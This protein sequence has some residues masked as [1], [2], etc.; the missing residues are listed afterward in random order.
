M[1]QEERIHANAGALVDVLTK[2]T[3][4][5]AKWSKQQKLKGRS[6]GFLYRNPKTHRPVLITAG[7]KMPK[8]GCFIETRMR[9]DKGHML[10]INAGK[11][12]VF[13]KQSKID[14]AFSELPIE[15]YQK[16]IEKYDGIDIIQYQAPFKNADPKEPH[17]FAVVNNYEFTK[18]E[19]GY[20]VPVYLCYEVGM[21]LIRQDENF[22][23][24]KPNREFQGD[25]YYE[26]ASGAPI[27]DSNGAISSILVS[28]DKAEGILKAFR[29]DNFDFDAHLNTSSKS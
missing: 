9:D 6:S 15:L 18:D 14:V 7:H 25:E 8:N 17:A 2:L 1:T 28:G 24:F 26:G 10:Q 29:L 4:R 16:D 23:Y 12:K 13:Y 21:E 11:F 5:I 19:N 27:A 3:F 20:V 22:N